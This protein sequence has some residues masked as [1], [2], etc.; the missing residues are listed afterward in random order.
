MDTIIYIGLALLL[1]VALFFA[2]RKKPETTQRPSADER[3]PP[4]KT[5]RE[6]GEKFSE[7]APTAKSSG[8]EPVARKQE[9]APNDQ[10]PS[11]T[12]IPSSG[13]IATRKTPGPP[14]TEPKRDVASLR[15]GL[16][17]S[18]G[19]EGFFGRIKGLFG[20]GEISPE[21]VE[22]LEEVLPTVTSIQGENHE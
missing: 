1:A 2:F 9:A 21:I 20:K 14:S 11:S 8:P 10:P 19:A 13:R 22:R 4:E 15:K 7:P 17:L 5:R 18:R 3:H 16:A 12:Q 6:L